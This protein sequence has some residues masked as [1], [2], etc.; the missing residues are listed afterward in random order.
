MIE[1]GGKHTDIRN[2]S[3]GQACQSPYLD[4]THQLSSFFLC[5]RIPS[6][7]HCSENFSKISEERGQ[8]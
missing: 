1:K 7:L 4:V 5:C 2:W 3:D 8:A 6:Y